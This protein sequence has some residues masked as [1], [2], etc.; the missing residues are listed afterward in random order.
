MNRVDFSKLS[1]YALI[2]APVSELIDLTL[3]Q[4]LALRQALISQEV[5]STG[6]P[7]LTEW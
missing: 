1:V 5:G 6:T 3:I 2:D 7:R 4:P